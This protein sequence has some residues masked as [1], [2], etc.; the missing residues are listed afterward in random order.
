VAYTEGT[1]GY[2]FSSMPKRVHVVYT[3]D[4]WVFVSLIA[5]G[6]A[7]YVSLAFSCFSIYVC[8]KDLNS[9]L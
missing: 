1:H 3:E 9:G 4:I 8:T 5:L 6:D 7:L 2:A